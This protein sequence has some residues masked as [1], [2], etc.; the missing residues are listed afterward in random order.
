MNAIKLGW[1][2]RWLLSLVAVSLLFAEHVPALL[3]FACTAA[4]AM[5]WCWELEHHA[6]S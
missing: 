3:C 2:M 1:I 4:L 5:F 6:A